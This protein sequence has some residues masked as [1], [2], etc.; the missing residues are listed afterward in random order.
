MSDLPIRPPLSGKEKK[1][2]WF[3]S[4]YEE[5]K[6][7][8]T[9]ENTPVCKFFSTTGKC[10]NGTECPYVHSRAQGTTI[11]QPCRYL[12]QA[13]FRCSKGLECHFSHDLH[14]FKCPHKNLSG[15][16]TCP[17]FCKFDHDPLITE[18][19]RMDFVRTNHS[20]LARP[21]MECSDEWKFYLDEFS[22]EDILRL[23]T[24]DDQTNFFRIS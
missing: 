23:E 7:M 19:E 10:R 8:R 15:G 4:R 18:G 1:R 2:N 6:R 3:G 17:P 9:A 14:L 16:T 11:Q 20:L 12:Y 5:S 22:D 13:P 24:R 21:G